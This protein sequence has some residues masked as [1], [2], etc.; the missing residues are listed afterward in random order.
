MPNHPDP[1]VLAAEIIIG[2]VH[3]NQAVFDGDC[4]EARHHARAIATQAAAT[5]NA[6]LVAAS[7]RAVALLDESGPRLSH[8]AR[9]AVETLSFEID[10]H[11][12]VSD[13]MGAEG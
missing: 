6:S 4:A 8:E 12:V 2:A 5:R 10:K 7:R 9:S 13:A 11:G 3:L 1:T